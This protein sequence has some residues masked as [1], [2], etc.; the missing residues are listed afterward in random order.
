MRRVCTALVQRVA[1]HNALL[2]SMRAEAYVRQCAIVGG[3][4]I[5]QHVRHT[6]DHLERVASLA[7]GD[8]VGEVLRYGARQRETEVETSVEAAIECASN[9]SSSFA[10]LAA[11]SF[12]NEGFAHQELRVSFDVPDAAE[13]AKAKEVVFTSTI[14]REAMFALHH[15]FHHDAMIAVIAN[16]QPEWGIIVPDGFGIAPSTKSF[17]AE[18]GGAEK[19]D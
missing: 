3:A 11:K 13:E 4:T 6:F 12:A 15:A 2:D 9:L 7:H 16:A 8:H 10:S 14:R 17:L 1:Q 19:E 5:G 18:R